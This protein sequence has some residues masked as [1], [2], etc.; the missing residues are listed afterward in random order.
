[1]YFVNLDRYDQFGIV[2]RPA[3]TRDNYLFMRN[4]ALRGIWSTEYIG[5]YPNQG[6]VASDAISILIQSSITSCTV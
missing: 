6:L 2:L 4:I 5:S 3:Q 1:M